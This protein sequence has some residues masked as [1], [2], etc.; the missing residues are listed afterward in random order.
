MSLAPE[1]FTRTMARVPGPVAVATT[2]DRAGRRWGSPP[3]RS[4]P[5]R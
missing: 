5:C 4:A 1:E 3:A 2:V